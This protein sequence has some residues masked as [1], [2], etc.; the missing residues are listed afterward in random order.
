MKFTRFC[1]LTKGAWLRLQLFLVFLPLHPCFAQYYNT[2]YFKEHKAPT[3]FQRIMTSPA[4]S[5]ILVLVGCAGL[6]SMFFAHGKGDKSEKQMGVGFVCFMLVLA[7]CWYRF[8]LWNDPNFNA[9]PE[10]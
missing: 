3:L 2:D 1:T 7:M 5:L 9:K 6:F 4:A 10:Y 8:S